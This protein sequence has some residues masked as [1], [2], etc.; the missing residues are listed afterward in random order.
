MKILFIN[1]GPWGT[2]SFT[3]SQ[4]LSREL[5]S[6]GHNVKIFFPDSNIDSSDKEDYYSHPELYSIW[7]F[8][9]KAGSSTLHTF[10]LMIGDPHPRNPDAITFKALSSRQL[11]AY[12][13]ELHRQL[14]SLINSFKPDIIECHH[15]W[16]PSW[17]IHKL[18][19]NYIVTAHHSDQLGF[20]YDPKV[21]KKAIEAANGAKKI[22]AISESVKQEVLELYNVPED[23][24]VV[25]ANGY[26]ATVFKPKKV[27]R[28]EVLQKLGIRIPGHAPIVSFAGKLSLT[29]GVDLLLQANKL[30]DASLGIHMIVMGAGEI[31]TILK[32]LSPASYS[33]KNVHFVGHQPPERVADIH[34]IAYLGVMPSRSEGFGISCLEAMGCGLPMIVTRSGGPEYFAVGKIITSESAQQLADGMM[35]LLKIPDREYQNL[36][37]K[38]L[39]AAQGY[40]SL[41][42]A[43]RHLALYD[44]LL[45]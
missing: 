42:I 12:Q 18:G 20:R 40:S 7:N 5:I 19:L 37:T 24:V 25:L 30:L 28:E 10:P 9:I 33:L 26:D 39:K 44:E 2:G 23:K 4:C 35:E 6:L 21:Q 3:L 14:S 43:Q 32:T 45:L 11:A 17:V 36:R 41:S 16:Y 22:I 15:I 8:P 1:T 31:D 13:H 27:N 29:K 34:H 38:A